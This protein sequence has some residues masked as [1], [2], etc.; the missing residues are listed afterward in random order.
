MYARPTPQPAPLNL[1][2][3]DTVSAPSPDASPYPGRLSE[4]DLY[5]LGV[6]RV[7]LSTPEAR[8]SVDALLALE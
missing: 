8:G 4:L 5:A 2:L 6:T 1:H 3:V 7:D